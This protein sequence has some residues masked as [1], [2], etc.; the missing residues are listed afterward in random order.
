MARLL[1]WCKTPGLVEVE[2]QGHPEAPHTEVVSKLD[3]ER[4]RA[5][6]EVLTSIPR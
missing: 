2:P 1:V 5:C 6:W 4:F 3:G